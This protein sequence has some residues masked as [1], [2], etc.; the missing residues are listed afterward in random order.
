VEL[1]GLRFANGTEV[2]Y[3]RLR[4]AGPGAVLVIPLLDNESVVLIR[5]YVAGTDRYE[6]GFPKGVMGKDE[7]PQQAA[8][9]EIMEEIGYGAGRLELL[10]VLSVA[11]GYSDFRTHVLLATE[12]YSRSLPGDEPEEIEVITW[13]LANLPR[14]LERED[15]V[16]ARSIAALYLLREVAGL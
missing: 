15:F 6:V 1:V 10:R 11:P 14:L 7:T 3:E 2:E 16:E 9:R 4:S 8:D 12:L 5:E 13:P